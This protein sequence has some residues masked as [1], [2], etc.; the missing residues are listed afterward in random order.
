MATLSHDFCTTDLLPLLCDTGN[1]SG[2]PEMYMGE[3]QPSDMDAW[4][5]DDDVKLMH[6]KSVRYSPALNKVSELR[7]HSSI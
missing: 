1:F 7:Y 6:K 3:I 4:V 5:M 2:R